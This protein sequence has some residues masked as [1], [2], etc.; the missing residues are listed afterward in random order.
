[1][2]QPDVDARKDVVG[3][4]L[5]ASAEL[6]GAI[7]GDRGERVERFDESAAFALE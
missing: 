5:A 7:S 3:R 4:I 6:G 1:M 2:F